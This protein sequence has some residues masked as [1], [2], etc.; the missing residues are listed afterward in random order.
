MGLPEEAVQLA[1]TVSS[2]SVYIIAIEVPSLLTLAMLNKLLLCS[3]MLTWLK[4]W[5]AD[6]LM[7]TAY[8]RSYG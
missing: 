8:R 3:L 1:L 5:P 6:R 4:R 7:M 2:E